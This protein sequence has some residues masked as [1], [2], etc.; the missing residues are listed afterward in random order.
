M[1][2]KDYL[3]QDAAIHTSVGTCSPFLPLG[4]L[5]PLLW[6][7][8]HIQT[9]TARAI[10]GVYSEVQLCEF[11]EL[12]SQVRLF[13][14]ADLIQQYRFSCPLAGSYGKSIPRMES[15]AENEMC[16]E[17]DTSEDQ[18]WM[19]S[20]HSLSESKGQIVFGPR[21]QRW[22]LW[23]LQFIFG[24]SLELLKSRLMSFPLT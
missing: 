7:R 19:P 8:V 3:I 12:Y 4:S 9:V 2:A 5:L 1:V 11:K 24:S 21:I 23:R 14:I 10:R 20:C 18:K 13:K 15:T 6:S 17:G 22:S 16:N